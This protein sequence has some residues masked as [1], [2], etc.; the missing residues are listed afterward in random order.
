MSRK[1]RRTS[2]C[3]ALRAIPAGSAATA[4]WGPKSI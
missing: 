2:M 3:V 4:L 1:K